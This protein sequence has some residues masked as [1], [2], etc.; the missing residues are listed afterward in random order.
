MTAPGWRRYVALG[1][2]FT[3]GMCDPAPAG[4]PHPWRGWADRL[5][6][7]LAARSGSRDEPFEYAN[8]AVRGKLLPQIIDE[9]VPVALAMR[10]D[11]VS[12]IGGGNDVLRPG[13]DV[14]VITARLEAPVARLRA[15][16]A[17]VIM[18]TAYDP[19]E[20]LVRRTRGLAATFTA[21][22][23][24]IAARQDAIVLDLWGMAPAL[25]DRRMW[26]ADRIHLTAE[27]HRRVCQQALDRL[28]VGGEPGWS[29]PLDPPPTRS[30]QAAWRDDAQ[31]V[32]EHLLPWVG[33][34][35]SGR[36]GR[37][38]SSVPG[39]SAGRPGSRASDR[40]AP[41]GSGR[42]RSPARSARRSSGTSAAEA[43]RRPGRPAPWRGRSRTARRRPAG[44][45]RTP[46]C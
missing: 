27:G 16:G 29:V 32:R 22:V 46:R 24:S 45:P 41:A 20:P 4:Q 13:V 43:G 28:G 3:E 33:P 21:N 1:D 7:S 2:S 25:R 15:A 8:L 35:S 34:A 40:V 12:L 30:R 42:A 23:W 38:R 31:W 19:W 44:R 37:S 10:P 9:Q 17:T 11:L 6:E 18:S 26:A 36:P 5:A 14:D 39:R